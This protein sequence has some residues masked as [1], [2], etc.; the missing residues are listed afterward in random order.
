MEAK[1]TIADGL[2]YA[3][4]LEKRLVEVKRKL[5]EVES[6]T[7][8]NRIIGSSNTSNVEEVT[9]YAYSPKEMLSAYDETSKELRLIRQAIERKNHTI[10]LDFEPKF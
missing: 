4:S 7:T 10:E 8:S 6:V 3:E 1:M 2:K 5:R 9:Q